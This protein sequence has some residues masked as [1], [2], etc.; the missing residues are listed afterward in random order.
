MN[1]PQQPEENPYEATQVADIATSVS[2]RQKPGTV[3]VLFSVIL[4]LV[5]AVIAF[6]ATFF[7]T[8]LGVLSIDGMNED[9][10]MVFASLVAGPTAVAAFIFTVWGFLKIV[11]AFKR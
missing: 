10:G 5:V 3:A 11:R 4:G 1:E 7:F 6:G 8:C 2:D 9:N